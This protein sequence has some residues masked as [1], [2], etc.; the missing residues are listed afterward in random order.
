MPETTGMRRHHEKKF[1]AFPLKYQY[2]AL[3]SLLNIY[4]KVQKVI[5]LRFR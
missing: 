5:I 4:A 1:Q 2:Q 3:P